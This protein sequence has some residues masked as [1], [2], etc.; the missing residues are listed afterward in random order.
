MGDPHVGLFARLLSQGMRKLVGA[1]Q[2]HNCTVIFINQIREKVGTS[3]MFGNPEITPGGKALKFY[4]SVRLDIRKFDTIKKEEQI[5]GSKTRVKVVKNKVAPPF[6]Q[7]EF[8]IMYGTG[9]DRIGELLE[10]SVK[11]NIISKSGAWH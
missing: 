5:I 11:N 9:V 10:I 2:K 4:F 1:I 7:A 8:N 6:K 3:E